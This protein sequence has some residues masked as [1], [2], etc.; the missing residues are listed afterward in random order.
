MESKMKIKE[1]NPRKEVEV[2]ESITIDIDYDSQIHIDEHEK[3]TMSK[4]SVQI[5]DRMSSWIEAYQSYVDAGCNY[6]AS[7]KRYKRKMILVIGL[8]AL[9]W[10]GSL[11]L[12]GFEI[13]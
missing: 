11:I 2:L 1:H 4:P 7:L 8:C 3:I 5:S 9:W 13:L 12:M 6:K 10:I